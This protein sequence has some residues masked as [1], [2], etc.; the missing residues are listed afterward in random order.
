MDTLQKLIAENLLNSKVIPI[1]NQAKSLAQVADVMER[2]RSFIHVHLCVVGQVVRRC[3]L[4][5]FLDVIAFLCVWLIGCC[6]FRSLH[7]FF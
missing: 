3:C 2:V 5:C 6:C 1:C 7:S 4:V